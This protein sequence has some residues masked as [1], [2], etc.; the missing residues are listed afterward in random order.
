M[1]LNFLI[2][3]IVL[4]F[5]GAMFIAYHT[6]NRIPSMVKEALRAIQ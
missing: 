1:R 5:D 2:E 6:A 4:Y 3:A